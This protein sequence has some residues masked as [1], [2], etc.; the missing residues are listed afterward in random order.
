MQSETV[1]QNLL[2]LK[3]LMKNGGLY[4]ITAYYAKH[5][6]NRYVV[7]LI[8]LMLSV[9]STLAVILLFS[10]L[11]DQILPYH[12]LAGGTASL[13]SSLIAFSATR[14]Y[15]GVLRYTTMRELWR[16]SLASI[17]KGL[18]IAVSLWAWTSSFS[19]SALGGGRWILLAALDM[20]FTLF[21]LIM[22]RVLLANLFVVITDAGEEGRPVR[23]TLVYGS[24][25]DAVDTL[26]YLEK[27]MHDQY[28][29]VGFVT[30]GKGRRKNLLCGYRIY[31]VENKRD[32]ARL[33]TSKSVT[34]L[35]FPNNVSARNEEDRIVRFCTE[36]NIQTLVRPSLTA[37]GGNIF[38][39]NI[40]EIKIEDLLGRDEIK[41]N[42]LDI[43]EF[44][45][46]KVV[47][48]TGG[49]G[50][51]GSELCRQLVTLPIRKLILMD[52]AETPMH[53]MVLE[54]RSQAPRVEK[55]FVIADVRDKDRVDAVFDKYHPN[56]VFHAAAYK[57]VPLMES[58]PCEAVKA[59]VFGTK[60]VV[61]AS[62]RLNVEKFVMISTDKAVNPTNVMGASKRIAEI[63]VQTVGKEIA[64]G[65]MHGKT[66]FVTTRFGNVLGSNGSVIPLFKEQIAKG[67]P[68]TVTDPRVIRYFMT[69]PEACSLVLEAATMGEGNDIFVF[70]MGE[71]VKID[72]LA[73]KMISLSGL[74]LG[75]DIDIKYV[76]LRPGEKLYEELL[77][78][79]E[80]TLPTVHE[81]IFRAKVREYS[82]DVVNAGL[83][84]LLAMTKAM[85][86]EDTVLEMKR[87][88]PEYKSANSRYERL[89]A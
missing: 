6:A 29:C 79:G 60:N 52:F 48:V 75:K 71:P 46:D 63:Y 88:V 31:H 30:S 51:I 83:E 26:N 44:L 37:F 84:R 47:V 89:D 12:Y 18:L 27:S 23:N 59:N 14:S 8:D 25:E 42:I 50:S 4:R 55:K 76:G 82:M 81:K 66:R 53:D 33:V 77:K 38:S 15:A 35:V 58:N 1:F 54:L 5:Y 41:V 74:Q 65:R 85:K 17:V 78:D 22:V 72:D 11:T 39:N 70:D 69:I 68:V 21:L 3:T 32:F 73:R 43:R 34:A 9:G 40:R 24:D 57:H 36:R 61:D 86:K 67:G 62:V 16:V 10:H 20:I 87:I 7:L 64:A 56:V 80:D 19:D 13:V 28:R 2:D 45:T 49:A